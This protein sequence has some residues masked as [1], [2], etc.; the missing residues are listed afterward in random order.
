MH[1]FFYFFSFY[2]LCICQVTAFTSLLAHIAITLY[3]IIGATATAA[4]FSHTPSPSTTHIVYTV[5][6][7]SF[8]SASMCNF[9]FPLINCNTKN[10]QRAISFAT[11]VFLMGII[12]FFSSRFLVRRLPFIIS[13]RRRKSCSYSHLP[14]ARLLLL[15]KISHFRI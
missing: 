15:R 8:T 5:C 6:V 14:S 9:K 11:F 13:F 2:P 3:T 7:H 10:I 4:A 1:V 12:V